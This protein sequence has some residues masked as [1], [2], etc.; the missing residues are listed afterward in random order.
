MVG[1]IIL[2]KKLVY[3]YKELLYDKDVRTLYRK[4]HYLIHNY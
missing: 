2:N 4:I 3:L 1:K